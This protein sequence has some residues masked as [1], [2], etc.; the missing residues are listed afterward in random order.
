MQEAVS[1]VIWITTD[2]A[3]LAFEQYAISQSTLIHQ[4]IRPAGS[5]LAELTPGFSTVEVIEPPSFKVVSQRFVQ[6]WASAEPVSAIT[7]SGATKLTRT[8]KKQHRSA[9][10]FLGPASSRAADAFARAEQI[11]A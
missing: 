1:T 11:R 4:R 9:A 5:V 2:R 3:H 10:F 8:K 6:K 7:G